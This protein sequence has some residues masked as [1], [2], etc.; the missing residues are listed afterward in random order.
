MPAAAVLWS[1]GVARAHVAAIY[2]LP[3]PAALFPRSRPGLAACPAEHAASPLQAE[4]AARRTLLLCDGAPRLGDAACSVWVGEQPSLG[5]P[6][7]A[8]GCRGAAHLPEQPAVH[9]CRSAPAGARLL[10]SGPAA[11]TAAERSAAA[12][13]APAAVSPAVALTAAA[14]AAAAAAEAEAAA[15]AAA[16]R[17]RSDPSA[18]AAVLRSLA[19]PREGVACGTGWD[20]PPAASRS[21]AAAAGSACRG[22]WRMPCAASSLTARSAADAG[23]DEWGAPAPAGDGKRGGPGSAAGSAAA[24]P[25]GCLGTGPARGNLPAVPR[26]PRSSR[27]AMAAACRARVRTGTLWQCHM[28]RRSAAH[29]LHK[30]IV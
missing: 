23:E 7:G 5:H 11:R 29:V 27:A 20:A 10:Q 24:A 18:A 26:R 28:T 25:S 22:D 12:A 3:F 19:A 8:R 9:T 1:P 6:L 30:G 13:A 4:A 16:D 15:A 14:A 17:A 2:A 21:M